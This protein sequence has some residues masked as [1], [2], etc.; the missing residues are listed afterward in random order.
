MRL[1]K[2]DLNVANLNVVTAGAA[3][4]N[5]GKS[6]TGS[7]SGKGGSNGDRALNCNDC[8]RR[9]CLDYDLPVC[10]DAEDED[11][12]TTCFRTYPSVQI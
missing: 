12:F 6:S 5:D 4:D 3:E 1:S 2:N 9:F 7:G 10:K 11:V 8:N